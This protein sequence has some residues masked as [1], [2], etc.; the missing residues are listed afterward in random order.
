MAA[1]KKGLTRQDRE[2][3]AV[4]YAD[5]AVRELPKVHACTAPAL[6]ALVKAHRSVA[7]A[8]SQ[9]VGIGF[10]DSTRTKRLWSV[11]GGVEKKVEAAEK[12]LAKCLGG[13]D[14]SGLRRR[15]T[16]RRSKR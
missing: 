2:S 12:S 15:R 3:N 8:R 6:H 9:L 11:V 4:K 16:A 13:G 14:L 5:A 10:S 1:P 7:Q